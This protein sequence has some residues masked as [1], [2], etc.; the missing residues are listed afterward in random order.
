MRFQNW[1]QRL[2]LRRSARRQSACCMLPKCQ[3]M[4]PPHSLALTTVFYR[5][6]P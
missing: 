2:E 6:P 5:Q 3:R 1:S 4:P